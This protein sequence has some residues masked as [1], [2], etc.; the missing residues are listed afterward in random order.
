MTPVKESFNAPQRDGDPRLRTT[1][2]E[3]HDQTEALWSTV[4]RLCP[5]SSE[6][7]SQDKALLRHSGN[8]VR[9][10]PSR[11]TH[12]HRASLSTRT[13]MDEYINY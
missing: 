5:Y 13:G 3:A 7:A 1:E 2:S 8:S 11:A 9:A 4:L 12:E 10:M 6:S